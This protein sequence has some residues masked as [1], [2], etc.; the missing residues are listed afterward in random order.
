VLAVVITRFAAK[1]LGLIAG[2]FGSGMRP[3][4]A[5]WVGCAMT[6]MSSVA[7][8]LTSQFATASKSLGPAIASTALPAILL[9]E[10]LGAVI[11]TVALYRAGEGTR[12]EVFAPSN[13]DNSSPGDLK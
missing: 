2:S 4:Q 1:I 6:P 5:L 10:V 13:S 8:L 7:L 12:P 3:M 11:A 9:M